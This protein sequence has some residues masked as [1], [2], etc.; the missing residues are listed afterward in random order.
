MSSSDGRSSVEGRCQMEVQGWRIGE[1]EGKGG[2]GK[3]TWVVCEDLRD[4]VHHLPREGPVVGELVL[5]VPYPPL[6]QCWK[7]A[8]CGPRRPKR[9]ESTYS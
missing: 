1:A 8:I 9:K 3:R 2:S 7:S 4:E 5:V 6:E